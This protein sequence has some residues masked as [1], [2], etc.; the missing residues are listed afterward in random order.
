[1]PSAP[2]WHGRGAPW[3]VR[4]CRTS[5]THAGTNMASSG[6]SHHYSRCGR[7]PGVVVP[8]VSAAGRGERGLKLGPADLLR[9]APDAGAPLGAK[10]GAW[11]LVGANS[12]DGDSQGVEP[13][14]VGPL[15]LKAGADSRR[16][17]PGA[18]ASVGAK[19]GS[20]SSLGSEPGAGASVGSNPEVAVSQGMQLGAG[21]PPHS[22]P[23]AGAAVGAGSR[24]TSHTGLV[25]CHVSRFE[26]RISHS[27][28]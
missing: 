20:G 4:S 21:S 5:H 28:A 22:K 24:P 17:E 2:G 19:P 12:G 15:R 11:P 27:D 8:L 26:T 14:A 13:G 1:M 9:S 10:P 3:D 7:R 25:V 18:G 16:S 6:T 23:G